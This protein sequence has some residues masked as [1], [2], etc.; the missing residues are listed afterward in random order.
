MKS[1]P[2]LVLRSRGGLNHHLYNNNGSLW[3]S[4]SV[5]LDPRHCAVRRRESLGTADWAVARDR[6]DAL[7][8]HLRLEL[9]AGR[10]PFLA[11]L[12]A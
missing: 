4:Y 7:F 8:A 2:E 1:R 6:R 10:V 3:V 9:A 11:S 12:A 5:R